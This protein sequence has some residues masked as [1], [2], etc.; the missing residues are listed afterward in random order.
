MLKI[1]TISISTLTFRQ[2]VQIYHSRTWKRLMILKSHDIDDS[3]DD[4]KS[5]RKAP[6]SSKRVMWAKDKVEEL[7]TFFKHH[8]HNKTTPKVENA[9][10]RSKEEGGFIHR[11]NYHTI[12]KKVS[13][14]NH[15]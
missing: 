9:I 3:S 15:K 7:N 5:K 11:R 2:R 1:S 13:A 12:V 8:F 4:D 14:M 6:K 10:K